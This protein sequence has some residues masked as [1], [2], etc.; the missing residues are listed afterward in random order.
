MTKSDALFTLVL[1]AQ[2]EKGG[3][4]VMY[5]NSMSARDG[6]HAQTP[7]SLPRIS[8]LS[9]RDCR[10]RR[11]VAEQGPACAVCKHLNSQSPSHPV[12]PPDTQSLAN[13]HTRT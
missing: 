7:R 8:P 9:G 3:R 12:D 4:E 10:S 1:T 13:I 11:A 6:S 5:L 2:D